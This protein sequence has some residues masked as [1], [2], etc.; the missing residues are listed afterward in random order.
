MTELNNQ[1]TESPDDE[2]LDEEE[3]GDE[4]YELR[5]FQL[6]TTKFCDS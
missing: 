2:I 5:S 6:V 4:E 3:N 1:N